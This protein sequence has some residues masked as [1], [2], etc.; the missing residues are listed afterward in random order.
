LIDESAPTDVQVQM[1]DTA[2]T[3]LKLNH[4]RT[5]DMNKLKYATELD[6]HFN[7][8]VGIQPILDKVNLQ[9]VG[10]EQQDAAG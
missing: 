5:A 1:T 4:W 9:P 10:T 8:S 6:D 3:H 2:L 7:R